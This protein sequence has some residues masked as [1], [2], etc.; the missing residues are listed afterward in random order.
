MNTQACALPSYTALLHAPT[1]ANN[2]KACALAYNRMLN[3]QMCIHAEE[4]SF[5]P[6]V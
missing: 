5:L 4:L 6:I 1:N 3:L 2:H